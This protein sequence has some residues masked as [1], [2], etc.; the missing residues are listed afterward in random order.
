MQ[1]LWLLGAT[2]AAAR[3]TP[4]VQ[5]R[6]NRSW[7]QLIER[8]LDA[9]LAQYPAIRSKADAERLIKKLLED[10]ARCVLALGT[11]LVFDASLLLHKKGMHH[12]E[13]CAVTNYSSVRTRN[14]PKF[15]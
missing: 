8:E 1:P 2:L 4:D 14:S 3:W 10:P 15:R 9:S 11:K 12:V 7:A 13:F 6:G 5:D